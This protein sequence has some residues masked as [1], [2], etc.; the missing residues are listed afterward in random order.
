[1][2]EWSFYLFMETFKNYCHIKRQITDILSHNSHGHRRQKKAVFSFLFLKL[3]SNYIFQDT[4]FF[5]SVLY[6]K[7][8]FPQVHGTP[9]A[10]KFDVK[11]NHTRNF[12]KAVRDIL[13]S[14]NSDHWPQ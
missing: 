12:N 1:M 2:F 5:S 14:L 13:V 7:F 9:A 4:S 10:A 6:G 11:Q 3:N 8:T